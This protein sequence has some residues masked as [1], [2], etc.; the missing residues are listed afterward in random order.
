MLCTGVG[1]FNRGIESFFRDCFNGLHPLAPQ[2]N[3][4]LKLFKGAGA[5]SR[6]ERRLWC[7][8]RTGRLAP[9]VGKLLGRNAYTIEQMSSLLPLA[10][11]L[12]SQRPDVLFTSEM[13][14][15]M[16]LPAL[17]RRLK[18]P[19]RFIYSNGAPL[20]GAFE[21]CDYVHQ[22]V[23]FYHEESLA[24]GGAA[25]RQSLVPYGINVPDGPPIT[26]P[27]QK[28]ALRQQLGLPL[29]RPIIISVGYIAAEHKRMD[30]TIREIARLPAPR[31]FLLMLGAMDGKSTPVIDLAK[32]E[33][34]PE[35]FL[36][37]SVPYEQV[38]PHYDA[39]DCFVLSSIQEGFGR[40]YIESLIHGLPTI[41]HDNP[42]MR[43]VLADQGSFADLSQPGNLAPRLADILSRPLNADSAISRR[44]S[45]R[46]R[47]SWPIL[48]P[49]YFEMFQKAA[50][51]AMIQ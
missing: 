28:L 50:A 33:L 4:D 23:P 35:N 39:A 20:R 49:A 47:F 40:V 44:E 15:L 21:N 17:R 27:A 29:D 36:A 16:R 7:L 2:H 30:Y 38:A 3:I 26:D 5:Q 48:A 13:N 25:L 31:P 24:S 45:V 22:I 42:V 37:R 11:V 10:G 9:A 32:Q 6:D 18:V 14:L 12:R 46:A 1:V 41:A 43:Y 19:F 34:G 51:V 8:P